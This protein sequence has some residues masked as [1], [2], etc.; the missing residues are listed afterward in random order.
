MRTIHCR[1]AKSTTQDGLFTLR[2]AQPN[3]TGGDLKRALAIE[4]FKD[5]DEVVILASE[6]H[7]RLTSVHPCPNPK[8]RHFA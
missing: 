7:E 2:L 3:T 5:G 1:I 8:A 4:G 6:E